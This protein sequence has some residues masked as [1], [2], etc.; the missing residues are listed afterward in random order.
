MNKE[1]QQKLLDLVK[2]NYDEIADDFNQTRRKQLWP[3]IAKLAAEV[4]DG[5]SVLDVGCGNGR[6]SAA[7]NG[8]NIKYVGVDNSEKLISLAREN[9]KAANFQFFPPQRDPVK[10]VAIFP[11]NGTPLRGGNFQFRVGDILEL[12]KIIED[13]F[14]YIFCVAVLHHL[15]SQALRLKALGQMK[16]RLKPGGKIVLTV[17]NLWSQWKYLKLILKFAL[18]RLIGKNQ[19]DF[20]D[21]LF[22]WG[23]DKSQ[24][25][26][27]AFTKKSLK[28]ICRLAELKIETIYNDLYNYYL[29]IERP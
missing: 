26:Y 22:N 13:K 14:D 20:G 3:E 1:I 29:V 27:H 2:Q 15:P 9:I 12:D 5:D 19:M 8:K 7:L 18:L 16:N 28:N 25:Y 23:G 4:P 17:W 6:L 11:A 10:A 24:R 21:I